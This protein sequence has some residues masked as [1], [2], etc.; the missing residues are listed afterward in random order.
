MNAI[1]VLIAVYKAR[2]FM[3]SKIQCILAQTA[4][5]DADEHEIIDQFT[6]KHKNTIEI[7]YPDYAKLYATWNHG[8]RLTQTPFLCNFNMDDQW[9]PQYL[10][11]CID[12][13]RENQDYATVSSQVLV[14]STPNQV[15]P[16]WKWDATMPSLPYPESSAGPCPVWRRSLHDRYGLFDDYYVIGDARMWEKWHAGGE[17][18]G[19]LKENLVL[20]YRNPDSLERRH[21]ENS[22]RLRD[23]DLNATTTKGHHP[24]TVQSTPTDD[25]Q[26]SIH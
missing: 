14:T 20:Y 18:F 25:G 4:F 24:Q 13:L 10:E 12:F 2:A 5:A 8:I 16:K 1:T 6:M 26:I 19:L 7:M 23:H 9:H 17:R 3:E 21:D 15:W 11:K 22:V